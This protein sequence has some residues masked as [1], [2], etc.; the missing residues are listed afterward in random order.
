MLFFFRL[1]EHARDV[2]FY[3]SAFPFRIS[4]HYI[5]WTDLIAWQKILLQIFSHFSVRLNKCGLMKLLRSGC[6][7]QIYLNFRLVNIYANYIFSLLSG[8]IREF[9][10]DYQS[11]YFTMDWRKYFSIGYFD[12]ISTSNQSGTF[13]ADRQ[14]SFQ[15]GT[16]RKLHTSRG[17]SMHFKTENWKNGL[18]GPR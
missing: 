12:A 7:W 16:L 17:R 4:P 14:T 11:T 5:V 6:Y 2:L 9:S 18:A 8:Y 15:Y 1:A 10:I 13:R 3:R